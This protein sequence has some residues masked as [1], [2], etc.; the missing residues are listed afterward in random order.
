MEKD[1]KVR[2]A[3]E[4]LAAI[5][6]MPE[7]IRVSRYRAWSRVRVIKRRFLLI[8]KKLDEALKESESKWK[9]LSEWEKYRN[10]MTVRF[11]RELK[12]ARAR[13][14]AKELAI[15]RKIRAK[16]TVQT[17]DS[18]RRIPARRSARSRP[19]LG[20]PP[21]NSVSGNGQ[22]SPPPH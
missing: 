16:L 18:A 6:S 7:T 11:L 10:R 4:R 22:S 21:R 2:V 19:R 14:M 12:L 3:A 17:V 13:V 20:R 5:R 8:A 9:D 1:P 15:V